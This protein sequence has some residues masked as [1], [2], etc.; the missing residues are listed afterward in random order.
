[1]FLFCLFLVSFKKGKPVKYDANPGSYKR[2]D[3][4]DCI[5]IKHFYMGRGGGVEEIP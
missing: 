4:F 2:T 1:M 5:N 3:K